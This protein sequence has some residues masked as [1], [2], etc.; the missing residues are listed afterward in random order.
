MQSLP[1]PAEA[2][3]AELIQTITS[4]ST[5]SRLQA[6]KLPILEAQRLGAKQ[7]LR[8]LTVQY[9]HLKQLLCQQLR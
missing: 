4:A 1:V 9:E 8:E 3:I 2:T 5:V 6:I 7:K